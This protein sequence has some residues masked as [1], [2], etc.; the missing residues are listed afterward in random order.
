MEGFR[1][2]DTPR[3]P[4]PLGQKPS[5]PGCAG[6]SLGL[7]DSGLSC[8]EQAPGYYSRVAQAGP[9][10]FS[11]LLSVTLPGESPPRATSEASE[12]PSENPGFLADSRLPA[13]AEECGARANL[14]A[15]VQT[16]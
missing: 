13:K 11:T 2:P 7:G 9:P 1:N 10:A 6:T 12:N 8:S 5:G 16:S 4:S 14:W 15:S 3:F